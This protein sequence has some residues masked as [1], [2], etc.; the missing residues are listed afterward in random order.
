[1]SSVQLPLPPYAS[2]RQ[3]SSVESAASTTGVPTQVVQCC[4]Y[5]Q[6]NTPLVTVPVGYWPKP[7]EYFGMYIIYAALDYFEICCTDIRF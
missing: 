7:A 1:M 2:T 4:L 6:W 5:N 3:V